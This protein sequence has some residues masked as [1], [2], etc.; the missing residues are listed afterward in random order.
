MK[1]EPF[2]V[3]LLLFLATGLLTENEERGVVEV[4]IVPH[5]HD[6]V[7]WILTV[8]EYYFQQVQFILDSCIQ[9]LLDNPR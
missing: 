9:Q 5:S 8:D 1:F 6:D 7:G 4:F 3:L 2:S